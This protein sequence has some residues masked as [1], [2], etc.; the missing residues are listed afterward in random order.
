[1]AIDRTTLRF[2]RLAITPLHLAIIVVNRD[3]YKKAL[4]L[5]SHFRP[6]VVRLVKISCIMASEA[7]F[8]SGVSTRQ[9]SENSTT[10]HR[11][12]P[13]H[14]KIQH[15]VPKG[16]PGNATTPFHREL[17]SKRNIGNP[18][19]LGLCAFA[20]TTFILSSI[21]MGILGVNTPAIVISSALAYGGLVQLLAG[22]WSVRS[23]FSLCSFLK[24]IKQSWH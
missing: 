22:M 18:S 23:L 3:H 1:M 24:T 7:E 8:V 14:V 17:S 6:P 5:S 21:N 12:R 2:W 15:R 16:Q 9:S 4:C 20:L 13:K 19:P 10:R 11:Y